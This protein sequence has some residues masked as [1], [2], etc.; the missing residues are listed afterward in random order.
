MAPEL[1][2]IGLLGVPFGVLLGLPAL[3]LGL[4]LVVAGQLAAAVFASTNANLEL[5]AIERGRNS[6]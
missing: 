4:V 6:F 1:A 5:V 3:V 2:A